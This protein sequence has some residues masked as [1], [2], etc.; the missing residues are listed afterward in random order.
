M[1]P[2]SSCRQSTAGRLYDWL[3]YTLYHNNP[4]W[5]REPT[6]DEREKIL[7]S[8]INFFCQ[9]E[10]FYLKGIDCIRKNIDAFRLLIEV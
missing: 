8:K 7:Y 4:L 6:T 5:R 3:Y 10:R 1:Y 2:V 9:N